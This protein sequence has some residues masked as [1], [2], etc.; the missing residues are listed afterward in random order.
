MRV[1]R[2]VDGIASMHAYVTGLLGSTLLK[3]KGIDVD[4]LI[5]PSVDVKPSATASRVA[6][7]I[8]MGLAKTIYS[9]EELDE[10]GQDI[11]F[12]F[13][14]YSRTFVDVYLVGLPSE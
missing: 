1:F 6:T 7:D 2:A 10:H 8:I 3:G 11:A 12:S 13:L 4:L 5:A 14:S 9:Y